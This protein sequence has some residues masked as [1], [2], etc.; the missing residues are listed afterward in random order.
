MLALETVVIKQVRAV[1]MMVIPTDAAI[2]KTAVKGRTN[3]H[4]APRNLG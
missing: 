1:Q 4:R 3:V 2:A